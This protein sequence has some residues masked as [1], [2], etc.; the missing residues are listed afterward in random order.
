MDGRL[1]NRSQVTERSEVARG[2]YSKQLRFAQLLAQ[3]LD[4]TSLS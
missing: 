4:V 3:L 1:Q 2:C